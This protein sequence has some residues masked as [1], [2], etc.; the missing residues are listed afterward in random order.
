MLDKY[1]VQ[2]TRITFKLNSAR[3]AD[4]TLNVFGARS[5]EYKLGKCLS[6]SEVEHVE[7][8]FNFTLPDCYKTFLMEI[9]NGGISY[10][11]SAA[12]PYYGIYPLGKN[13]DE[14]AETAAQ[15]L[16]L[17]AQIG[18]NQSDE[19]WELLVSKLK[20]EGLSDE[21]YEEELGSLYAG[22]MPLGSQGCTYLH[23]LIVTGEYAGRVVNANMDL[24]KPRF[25]FEKNFL[26]WYER[27]LDEVISGVLMA[28]GPSWYGYTMGG[29][30]KELLNVYGKE[31][32]PDI[33]YEALKGMEKLL[34][35]GEDSCNRLLLICSES[36]RK[37]VHTAVQLLTKFSYFKA[38]NILAEMI[39]GNDQDC[40]AACQGLFWYQREH[41]PD[42][43]DKLRS[44]LKYV[45]DADTFRFITYLIEECKIDYGSDLLPFFNHAS[46][47]IR[48]RSY[49]LLGKLENKRDYLDQFIAGLADE[50]S[51][52]VHATLQALDGV[53]DKILLKEYFKV[54]QR[55][56]VE[57]DSVLINLT[58]RLKE[59]GFESR[60]DFT[61][62]YD[63]EAGIAKL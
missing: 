35:I 62:R 49:Y 56:P 44:R 27:W 5:H 45:D 46:S 15:N 43:L 4:S 10:D 39:N 16:G 11:G 28:P 26:D 1:Q 42:W 2:A 57:K 3:Q 22:I 47:E 52:V 21:D 55:Y 41:A 30:D 9:G 51:L 19:E 7:K 17:P 29:D 14:L 63:P 32:D 40:L 20:N 58:H 60:L 61:K 34:A 33:Q 8:K 48:V 18:P 13:L 31:T 54:L 25:C 36:D 53:K 38:V 23:A 59:H 50:S 12:G 6:L 37:I 24:E